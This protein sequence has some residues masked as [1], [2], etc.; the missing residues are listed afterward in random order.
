M[1]AAALI[2]LT[3]TVNPGQIFNG[4][5]CGWMIDLAFSDGHRRLNKV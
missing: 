3:K 1:I 4:A 2:R 5:A